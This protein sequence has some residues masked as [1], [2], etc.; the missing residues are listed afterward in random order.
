MDDRPTCEHSD[1]NMT[2]PPC[3]ILQAVHHDPMYSQQVLQTTRVKFIN[4]GIAFERVFHFEY[5]P[6]ASQH[7]LAVNDVG[8]FV[9][10]EAVVL[11]GQGGLYRSYAI[12]TAQAG[13]YRL[14]IDSDRDQSR[15]DVCYQI[16]GFRTDCEWRCVSVH[17]LTQDTY[18]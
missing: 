9:K 18:V 8:D 12:P 3:I 14:S 11:Y 4:D 15:A 1:T 16:D 2:K 17:G 5:F 13:G 6:R 7:P 10:G